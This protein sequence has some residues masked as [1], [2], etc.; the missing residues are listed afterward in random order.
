MKIDINRH[1]NET[2]LLLS[3]TKN[4]ETLIKQIPAE[5]QGSVEFELIKPK[6]T[7]SN[8]PSNKLGL[9]SNWMFGLTNLELY[10][11]V[12]NIADENNK[13]DLY[14]NFLRCFHSQKY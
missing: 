12:L 14:T 3:I 7:F 4:C 1:Q 9:E 2:D 11:S 6:E 13:F 5:L 8:K 10:S